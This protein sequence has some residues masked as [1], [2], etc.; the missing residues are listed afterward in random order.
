[1]ARIGFIL[2][3]TNILLCAQLRQQRLRQAVRPMVKQHPHMPW[4]R[5]ASAQAGGKGMN[6]DDNR[7][8]P[9]CRQF[10]QGGVIGQ[11][12]PI[13]PRLHF[14]RINIAVGRNDGAIIQPH[15]QRGV[16]QPAVGVNH[17]AREVRT[18]HRAVQRRAQRLCRPSCPNIIGNMARHI[19]GRYAQIAPRHPIGHMVA[20]MIAGDQE[21]PRPRG[22]L[23]LISAH[24]FL[25]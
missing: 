13:N 16:I 19:F 22:P 24:L 21:P 5:L 8:F 15:N 9:P 12:Q 20:G 4:A 11:I 17:K 18:N 25:I 6:G 3:H 14:I 1:M 10:G 7:I 23:N 2:A